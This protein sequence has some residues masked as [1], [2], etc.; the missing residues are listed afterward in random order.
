MSGM[1]VNVSV[2][3]LGAIKS[4]VDEFQSNVKK[5]CVELEEAANQLKRKSSAEDIQ[6]IIKTVNDIR[7]IIANSDSTFKELQSKIEN[8]ISV[9]NRLKAIARS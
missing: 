3:K 4:Y 7:E 5:A 2:E 1:S 6:D 9:V 8:Y